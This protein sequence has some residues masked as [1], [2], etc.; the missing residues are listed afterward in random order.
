MFKAKKNENVVFLHKDFFGTK[1]K[2]KE[3]GLKHPEM[4]K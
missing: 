4:Q 1:T 2:S 3:N